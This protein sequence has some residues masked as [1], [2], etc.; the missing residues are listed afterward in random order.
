MS[1]SDLEL[2]GG[3]I[4]PGQYR[5]QY[6]WYDMQDFEFIG[7]VWYLRLPWEV[8]VLQEKKAEPMVSALR[9]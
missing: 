5:Q 8:A 2:L 9:K 7:I 1:L 3:K 4:T 6:H